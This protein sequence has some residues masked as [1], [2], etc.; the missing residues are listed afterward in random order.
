MMSSEGYQDRIL[1][2]RDCGQ[3]FTFTSGEQE[4]FASRGLTNAPSRCPA[5]RAARRSGSSNSSSYTPHAPR[6]PRGSGESYQA[7]CANCGRQT[8]VP[9][10][11]TEGRAVYCNECFQAVRA[12]RPRRDDSRGNYNNNSSYNSSSSYSNSGYS[13]NYNDGGGR[14]RRDR[15]YDRRD[16]NDRNYDRGNDRGRR[17]NSQWDDESW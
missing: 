11:P 6:A 3:E 10:Q 12:S 4:F 2:C 9:F 1:T 7:V 15:N 8:T 16:R 14:D 5:C 13:D 17:R